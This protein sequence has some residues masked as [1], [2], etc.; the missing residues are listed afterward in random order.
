MPDLAKARIVL[1]QSNHGRSIR[2]AAASATST[3]GRWPVASINVDS[4][5]TRQHAVNT[6]HASSAVAM[7]TMPRRRRHKAN[8]TMNA[9]MPPAMPN[10]ADTS[11]NPETTR[12]IGMVSADNARKM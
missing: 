9:K 3:N 6:A 11:L 1:G 5:I 12:P 8:Q 2:S 4:V 10:S 7:R